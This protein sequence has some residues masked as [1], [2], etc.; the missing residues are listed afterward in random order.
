[1]RQ[2]VQWA[3]EAVDS[4]Y[5]F[6]RH[7]EQA[8]PLGIRWW[9]YIFIPGEK[10]RNQRPRLGV[11]DRGFRFARGGRA[12]SSEEAERLIAEAYEVAAHEA[13]HWKGQ[14]SHE[15]GPAGQ[16]VPLDEVTDLPALTES[17]P[18]LTA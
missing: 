4:G 1:V 5:E 3:A 12:G 14:P 2:P 10:L 17:Y 6:D 9:V 18:E 11:I 13:R 16:L 8:G 15:L 7:P